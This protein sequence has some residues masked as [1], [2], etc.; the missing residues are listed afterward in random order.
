[1]YPFFDCGELR[2][3]EDVIISDY[4]REGIDAIYPLQKHC[5][6][7]GFLFWDE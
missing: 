7:P 1:M 4:D 3:D 5:P 2:S 6:I